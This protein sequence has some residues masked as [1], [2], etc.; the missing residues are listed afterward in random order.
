MWTRE[1]RG[2]MAESACKTKRYPT[3]LTD[4]EWE[5]I[6]PLLP[7]VS[8]RG[9]RPESDL[10]LSADLDGEQDVWQPRARLRRERE[11]DTS[12]DRRMAVPPFICLHTRSGSFSSTIASTSWRR[13]SW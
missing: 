9:H 1:S 8:E 12:F 10:P 4:E 6:K 2:R 5:R 3:D 11:A 7:K 13:R